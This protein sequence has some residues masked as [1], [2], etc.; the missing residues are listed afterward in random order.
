MSRGV[1]DMGNDAADSERF[2]A[3]G[4]RAPNVPLTLFSSHFSRA[5]ITDNQ[6]RSMPSFPRVQDQEC[7]RLQRRPR[8]LSRSYWLFDKLKSGVP[9][10]EPVTNLLPITY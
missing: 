6:P 7:I 8:T 1:R 10:M 5:T 3:A 2:Y 9:K 4:A